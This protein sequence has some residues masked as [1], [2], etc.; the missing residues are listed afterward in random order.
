V[1]IV[2][3]RPEVSLGKCLASLA[4]QSLSDFEVIV[5]CCGCAVPENPEGLV[6]GELAERTKF[7]ATPNRGYGAACNLGA[8]SSTAGFLLFLN[9]DTQLHSNCIRSLHEAISKDES[10]VYQPLIFHEYANRVLRGNPCDIYGAAGLGFYGNCGEG[11]FYASGASLATSRK[12]FE[13]LGGFDE[14]L[15]LYHD[16]LDL[17]WRARLLGYGVSCVDPAT[18]KHAGGASSRTMPHALKFYFT[19]RNRIRVMIKNYSTRRALTRVAIACIMVIMGG[20]FL[21][22]TRHRAQYIVSAFKAF[23][24]NLFELQTTLMERHRVQGKRVGDDRVI[25][26][27]MSRISMDLCVLKQYVSRV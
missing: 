27:S 1:I 9:D 24:W 18:C 8:R 14:E 20:T 3:S 11:E 21:A 6:G 23:G 12:L 5:V 13:R 2:T 4:T 15:F 22:L 19:Q 17:S 25:E 7:I 10:R 26:R 16:D